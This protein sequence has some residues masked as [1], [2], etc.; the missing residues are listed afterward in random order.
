MPNPSLPWNRNRIKDLRQRLRMTQEEISRKLGVKRRTWQH[1]ET[2]DR[3]P[4]GAANVVLDQ[5]QKLADTRPVPPE[6][7]SRQASASG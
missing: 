5:L 6:P 2:G 7:T 4:R 1:W 3:L